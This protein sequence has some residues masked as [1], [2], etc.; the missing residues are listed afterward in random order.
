M[1]VIWIS[2]IIFGHLSEL[3]EINKYPS[4]TWLDAAYLALEKVPDIELFI[5]TVSNVNEVKFKKVGTLTS[6]F[7]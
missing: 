7:G 4:G 3:L 6:A 5:I 1:R 2:N